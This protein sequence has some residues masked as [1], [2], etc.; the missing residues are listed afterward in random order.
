MT[1]TTSI[2]GE[3]SRGDARR[4]RSSSSSGGKVLDGIARLV[5]RSVDSLPAPET[6]LPRTDSQD[7]VARLKRE[8]DLYLGLL[9][10]DAQVELD[11]FLANAL[12]LVVELTGAK[13]AY[14]ELVTDDADDAT[15]NW[16]MAHGFSSNQ[17]EQI[18]EAISRGIVASAL[19]T[20]ETVHTDS[21]SLDPR[22]Q[23]RES[24]Q[25][26]GIEA[27]LCAPI[28]VSPPLGVLYLQGGQQPGIFSEEDRA[29]AEIFARHLAPL[30]E[31][32][33][34]RT[35]ERQVADATVGIR[36][37]L[38]LDE[39]VGRSPAL[40]RVLEQAALVMPLD[41]NVLLTGDSGTGKS[42]LARVIHQNGPRASRPFVELNCAALQ[43]TLI[44]NELF[45]ASEG[46]HS[47]ATRAIP[48]KVA[49]AERG[50]L[51]LDEIGDLPLSAQAKL[52]QLL[53]SRTYFPVG[54]DQPV[55][56]N[57]RVIAATNV[58]LEKAVEEK[59]FR[60]DLF[61]RLQVLPIRLPSLAERREDVPLLAERMLATVCARHGFA[62][63]KLSTSALNA[64]TMTEWR[65][66]VREL[67]HAIEAAAIRATGD[68]VTQVERRHIFPGAEA[69]GA[70][71][72][73]V[74][75]QAA[76]REFQRQLLARTLKETDWNVAEAGRRLELA[77]SHVYTLIDSFDLKDRKR[78]RK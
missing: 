38:P 10:L 61:F 69:D 19:A 60:E 40:A 28:G 57:V 53:Q 67:G 22:F 30:V 7:G 34:A 66:N 1:E 9:Q 14:L 65:G 21:A 8:R 29:S 13:H 73:C 2:G 41:V 71:G 35:R 59:R 42:Q 16:S 20:G 70:D 45:G 62:H 23:R 74:T 44:E 77:R 52:L 15:G 72:A 58:D 6:S 54:A 76:T 46:G 48:G 64:I 4:R 33:L 17:V 43:E 37:R 55:Q 78:S 24:V 25:R 32:V 26:V 63:L 36:T 18:R 12:S 27:V 11:P 3:K 68:S 51:F 50:T 75:Y 56:A 49:A 31:R 5:S 47:T 39:I